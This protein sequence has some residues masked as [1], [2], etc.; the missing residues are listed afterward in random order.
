MTDRQTPTRSSKLKAKENIYKY[1]NNN[2]IK[3][4]KLKRS[5][6]KNKERMKEL[7]DKKKL[8][9]N[10]HHIFK[11]IEPKTRNKGSKYTE[12]TVRDV[13]LGILY[14][15]LCYIYMYISILTFV[16]KV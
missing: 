4:E 3:K 8:K 2:E 15:K 10:E 7:R 14:L 6:N 5:T 12:Q 11:K 13:L 9:N 16:C 1:V